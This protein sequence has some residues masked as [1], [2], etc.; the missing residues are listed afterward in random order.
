MNATN[1]GLALLDLGGFSGTVASITLG[2]TGGLTAQN[3]V[4]LGVGGVLNL[5]GNAGLDGVLT[6][7]VQGGGL[8]GYW[9]VNAIEV[10]NTVA[11]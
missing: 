10:N 1:N 8:L 4:A 5:N 2:G 7:T 11:L 9:A 3:N 6:I